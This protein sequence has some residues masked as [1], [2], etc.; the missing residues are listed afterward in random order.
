M[1]QTIVQYPEKNFSARDLTELIGEGVKLLVHSM[2]YTIQGEGIYAGRPAVFI[3]LGGC[4]R[5]L[6]DD[7]QWCDSNFLV[8]E[9]RIFTV[10]E[11]QKEV[12][13]LHHSNLGHKQLVVI[14][15][16]EP[17]LQEHLSDLVSTLIAAGYAVQIET[18]GDL[19][20]EHSVPGACV[21]VSPKVSERSG[22]YSKPPKGM[23]LRADYLK[24]IVS[25]DPESTYHQLP[26]YLPEFIQLH[27][28][29]AV[30]L[31]PVNEHLRPTNPG[32][33]ASMWTDLYDHKKCELNHQYAAKL[34][35][36]HQFRLSLQTHAFVALP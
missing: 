26:D 1:Y 17:L 6:K 34:V 9:S 10:P 16:G 28:A 15:G 21:V 29:A 22:K 4:N 33:V 35:L 11:I 3:R 8:S 12:V 18:N 13:R 5:G 36:Q 19:L 7:C 23:L 20:R 32:E 2:W 14:T 30:Y 25:A 27:S 24:I 31:S